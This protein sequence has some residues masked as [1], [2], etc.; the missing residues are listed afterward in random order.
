MF[1]CG[2]GLAAVVLCVMVVVMVLLFVSGV[3]VLGCVVSCGGVELLLL[4]SSVCVLDVVWLFVV[5]CGWVLWS[6]HFQVFVYC[7]ILMFV[8]YFW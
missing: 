1:G 8:Q 3:C 5:S 4:V 2:G 7:A 6:E